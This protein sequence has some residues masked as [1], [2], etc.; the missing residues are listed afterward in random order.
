MKIDDSNKDAPDRLEKLN[1]LP[2]IRLEGGEYTPAGSARAAGTNRM[3]T[4]RGC[5]GVSRLRCSCPRPRIRGTER[6]T[7]AP[8]PAFDRVRLCC[9]RDRI[10]DVALSDVRIDPADRATWPPVW[11]PK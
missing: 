1:V 5:A 6:R 4:L 9:A 11:T 10:A 8:L 2:W 3:Q 7:G